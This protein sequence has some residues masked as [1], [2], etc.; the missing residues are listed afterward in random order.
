MVQDLPEHPVGRRTVT[1]NC[2]PRGPGLSL[3]FK[4]G[5]SLVFKVRVEGAFGC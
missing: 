4:V 2:L 3:G 5:V 1:V